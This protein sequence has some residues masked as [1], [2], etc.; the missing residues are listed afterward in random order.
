MK[1]IIMALVLALGFGATVQARDEIVR[2]I[3]QLPEQAK[4]VLDKN[5]KAKVSFIKID[6]NVLNNIE[7]YEVVLVDGTE[8]KFDASGAWDSV[9]TPLNKAVPSAFIPE[10]TA[11]FV[12]NNYK[13]ARIVSIDKE[14]YGYDVELS[15]GVDLVFDR[16]GVFDHIDD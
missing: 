16:N 13:R 2:D 15:N 9:E 1:K 12:K 5:F 3:N 4:I 8:V 10:K 7:D 6:R 14:R 11:E